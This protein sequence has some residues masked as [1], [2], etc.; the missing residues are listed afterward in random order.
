MND[1]E[2]LHEI[3]EKLDNLEK[4]VKSITQSLPT[5]SS[6]EHTCYESPE[7]KDLNDAFAQAQL[8]FPTINPNRE[9]PYF[10]TPYAD[11]DAIMV[12]FRPI[13]AKNGLTLTQRT[14]LHDG[15]TILQTRLWHSSGQWI[16]SRARFI[17]SKNDPHTYGSSL[18]YLKRVQAVAL[19]N[20]TVKDDP[21]DDDAELDMVAHRDVKA[22]GTDLS[23][24]YKPGKQSS[25]TI[26]KEQ[27]E[28]IEYELAKYPDIGEEIL[29]RLRLQSIADLPKSKY[30]PTITRIREIK[31]LRDGLTKS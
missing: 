16:E 22:R 17:P 10:K 25:E 13:L 5:D 7:T 31:N 21:S 30:L 18:S 2:F 6:Y 11:L 3:A 19:L 28:E 12:L 26:T 1:L 27:I 4:L 20:V 24:K 14:I 29:E 23:L 9:N 8:E 15:A